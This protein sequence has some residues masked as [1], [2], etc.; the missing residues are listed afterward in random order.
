MPK[1]SLKIGLCLYGL[2]LVV[3]TLLDVFL[4]SPSV[5]PAGFGYR[6]TDSFRE[7]SLNNRVLVAP[8]FRLVPGESLARLNERIRQT[9]VPNRNVHAVAHGHSSV[10][11]EGWVYLRLTNLTATPKD[12]VL[13]TPPFR[14]SRATLFL[15]RAGPPMAPPIV[16][17]PDSVAT[18]LRN[19]ST[20]T[21]LF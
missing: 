14:C 18:L 16:A 20:K 15:E 3:L 10:V 8:S 1:F 17:P 4:S 2:V 7:T 19:I 6:L 5:N 9:F 13:S 21:V 11:P 12:V